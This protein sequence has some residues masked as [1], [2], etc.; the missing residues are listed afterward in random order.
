MKIHQ[1]VLKW[2]SNSFSIRVLVQFVL[3]APASHVAVVCLAVQQLLILH[4]CQA[5]N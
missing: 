2:S 5:S 4:M 1:N 3:K